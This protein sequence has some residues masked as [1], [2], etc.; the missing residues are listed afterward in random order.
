[1]IKRVCVYCGCRAGIN[2]IYMESA[3]NLGNV[4]AR[5]KVEL[6][7]GGVTIGLMG[8]LADAMLQAGG[9]VIGVIPDFFPDQVFHHGLSELYIVS[10]LHERKQ[11]MFELSDAFIALP[12]GLGTLEELSELMAWGQ[13]GIHNKPYG[14][15]NVAGYFNSLLAF[16]DNTIGEGFMKPEH[17]NT[18]FVENDSET[19][20]TILRGSLITEV[21]KTEIKDIKETHW[22]KFERG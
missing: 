19:L 9:K 8:N 18:I 7:Y 13:I 10:S 5:H 14:I 22:N 6:V 17:R 4:L 11:L 15:L 21:N 16:L 3:R 2:N 20:L 1:M 12:G